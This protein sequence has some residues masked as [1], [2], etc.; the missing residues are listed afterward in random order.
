[1]YE[2]SAM[3][4]AQPDR[5]VLPPRRVGLFAEAGEPFRATYQSTTYLSI[6]QCEG[7]NSSH[8]CHLMSF[9]YDDWGLYFLLFST[10]TMVRIF[11]LSFY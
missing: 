3:A 2:Q 1:M 9:D 5:A 6:S 7:I 8:Y 4:E 10:K 11:C